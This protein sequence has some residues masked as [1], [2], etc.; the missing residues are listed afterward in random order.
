MSYSCKFCGSEFEE[1]PGKSCP[2]CSAKGIQKVLLV[3]QI[4][5]KIPWW[6][7]GDFYST[8]LLLIFLTGFG[9]FFYTIYWDKNYQQITLVETPLCQQTVIPCRI[10]VVISNTSDP[11][12][13]SVTDLKKIT[14]LKIGEELTVSKESLTWK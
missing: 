5:P 2:N 3:K 9:W 8:V 12:I 6:R 14:D 13:W 4:S 10:K 7:D 1:N 11:M